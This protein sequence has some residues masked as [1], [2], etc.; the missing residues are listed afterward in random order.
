M[1]ILLS[2]Q[3]L[4]FQKQIIGIKKNRPFAFKN[5]APFV[6]CISKTHNT[7]IDNAEDLDVVIPMYNL[8]EY[9]RNYRTATG[10]LW[11]YYRYDLR[12]D[13]SNNNNNN[14]PNKNVI[15]SESFK[16]KTSITRSIYAM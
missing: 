15:K 3:R 8:I 13:A 11:N 6:S 14:N 7:F 9:S 4:L 2:K 12:D 10:S 5:N 16:Y 1:Y